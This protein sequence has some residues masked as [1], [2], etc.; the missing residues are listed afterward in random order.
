[1]DDEEDA[2]LSG[3]TVENDKTLADVLLLLLFTELDDEE[4]AT[5]AEVTLPSLLCV[6]DDLFAIDNC[7]LVYKL[8]SIQNK[9]H[10]PAPELCLVVIY[11]CLFVGFA[12]KVCA[13][14]CFVVSVLLCFIFFFVYSLTFTSKFF[15]Q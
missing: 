10:T 3:S 1:M 12:S 2:A 14:F 8:K 6:L 9:P 7:R 11:F 5:G 15:C 13:L 4:D